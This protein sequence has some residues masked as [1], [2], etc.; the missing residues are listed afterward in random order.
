MWWF[1]VDTRAGVALVIEVRQLKENKPN[2][3]QT[4][5]L[6]KTL[7]ALTLSAVDRTSINGEAHNLCG[8][9]DRLRIGVPRCSVSGEA[10]PRREKDCRVNA[11]ELRGGRQ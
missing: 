3:P 6:T 2:T 1:G 11:R 5:L 9:T 4:F 10:D 7:C 8:D